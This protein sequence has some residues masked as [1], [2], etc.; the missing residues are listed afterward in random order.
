[1]IVDAHTHIFPPW[2][3][4]HRQRYVELDATFNALYANPGARL[5]TAEGLIA[6]MDEAGIDMAVVAGI[7]WTDASLA[8]ECNDYLI[9]AMRRFPARLVGL[10]SVNPAWGEAAV[11]EVER[12]ARQGIRGV[13]ELHPDTQGFDLGSR[14]AMAPLMEAVRH[15]GLIVLTHSSE[16]VGHRYPGKGMTTPPVLLR[17]IEQFP[18]IPIVCAHW[19]GGLPFYALMPEV[20][21]ALKDVYFDTAATP[22][23]YSPGVFSVVSQLV[24]PSHILLGTDY[25][26]MPQARVLDQVR[27]A[28][29]SQEVRESILGENAARLLGLPTASEPRCPAESS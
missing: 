5:T 9:E 10:C 6:A 19:G 16:P 2:L 27:E 3:Q 14:E 29:L 25:P 4:E 8:Q 11:Q 24:P 7:G 13:G 1:M 26:L 28:P 12:C 22:F 17:F 20:A 18:G 23:L 15:L 21:A